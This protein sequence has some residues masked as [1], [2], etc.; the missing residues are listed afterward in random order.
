MILAAPESLNLGDRLFEALALLVIAIVVSITNR[1]NNR[2]IKN[3]LE[4]TN[5]RIEE[6]NKKV[7]ATS[8]SMDEVNISLTKNNGGST[9]KDKLDKILNNQSIHDLKFKYLEAQQDNIQAKQDRQ[10]GKLD[11]Q[12]AKMDA[13]D[14]KVNDHIHGSVS[15]RKRKLK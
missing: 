10:E 1:I 3:K 9:V 14:K 8:S 11:R 15:A 4:E 13:I 12:D 7:D 2:P 5:S 6:T